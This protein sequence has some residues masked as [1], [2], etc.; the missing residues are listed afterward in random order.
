M[1]RQ[2]PP[3]WTVIDGYG[4]GSRRAGGVAVFVLGA[5][6]IGLVV[7]AMWARWSAPQ[8]DTGPSGPIEWN[9]VQSVPRRAPDAE[10][11]EWEKRAAD[12]SPVIASS[13]E[14]IQ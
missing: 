3:D 11:A 10:D 1:G 6:F 7:A 9:E 2:L 4:G 13:S 5:V 8:V 12:S 14:A